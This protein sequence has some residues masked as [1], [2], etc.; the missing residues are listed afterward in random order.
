MA[1]ILAARLSGGTGRRQ[2]CQLAMVRTSIEV[3]TVS[4]LHH[5]TTY[6]VPRPPPK[7]RSCPSRLKATSSR[8]AG[9]PETSLS[10]ASSPLVTE[11]RL[12]TIPSAA[13]QRIASRSRSLPGSGS[14]RST[15]LSRK[16]LILK[17]LQEAQALL[18][19]LR[20]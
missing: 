14:G 12:A 10:L 4:R 19:D 6:L 20:R 1:G 18:K 5:A 17:Y 9:S 15:P 3:E 8:R 16:G 2:A 11:P 7:R 13:C